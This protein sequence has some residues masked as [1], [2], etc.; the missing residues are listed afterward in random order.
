MSAPV[1]SQIDYAPKPPPV[2]RLL[3][4]A[5]RPLVYLGVVA[6][7]CWAA[8]YVWQRARISYLYRQCA[9]F[10]AAPNQL[11]YTENPVSIRPLMASDPSFQ[12]AHNFW[13]GVGRVSPNWQRLY[14]A[15]SPPGFN[16]CGTAFLHE[17][18]T[19]N[20]ARVLVAVDYLHATALN[21]HRM[22]TFQVRVFSRGWMYE[23]P[24]GLYDVDLQVPVAVFPDKPMQLTIFAGQPDPA[25]ASHFTIPYEIDGVSGMI[26]GWVRN[27]GSVDL[28]DRKEPLTP[29]LPASP[30]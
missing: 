9:A 8:P 27:S 24:T 21:D 4:R 30:D 15:L 18:R 10:T 17:C 23:L 2:R 14:T 7:L 3:R 26:D 19:P 13:G 22:V 28:E 6:L 25:D 11:V 5:V 12:M 16:S 29:P 1:V 20:G